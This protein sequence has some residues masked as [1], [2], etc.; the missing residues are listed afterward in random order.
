MLKV[1]TF[2]NIFTSRCDKTI[3]MG[4]SENGMASAVS[5][6]IDGILKKIRKKHFPL[7]LVG[8]QNRL[9]WNFGNFDGF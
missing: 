2:S 9:S 6:K 4:T 3:D 7:D 5:I 8:M 1:A